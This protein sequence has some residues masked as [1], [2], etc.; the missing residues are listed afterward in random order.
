MEWEQIKINRSN[1]KAYDE[2]LLGYREGR[3]YR[4]MRG[5][6]WDMVGLE[7]GWRDG[8]RNGERK[9]LCWSVKCYVEA[10]GAKS[11]L[12]HRREKSGKLRNVG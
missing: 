11:I 12:M 9:D 3:E 2:S 7:Q 8:E 10:E 5:I 4:E 1:W 6:G